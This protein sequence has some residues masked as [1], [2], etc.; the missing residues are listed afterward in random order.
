MY[1]VQVRSFDG[2]LGE[3]WA[4]FGRVL[5]SGFGSKQWPFGRFASLP[6]KMLK[7]VVSGWL[8][9]AIVNLLGPIWA[10]GAILTSR[11]FGS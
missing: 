2:V 6:E 9:G 4:G 11:I 1:R 7:T 8:L 5:F 3:F 10:F